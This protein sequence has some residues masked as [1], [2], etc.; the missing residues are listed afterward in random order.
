MH[1]IFITIGKTVLRRLCDEYISDSPLA[2][3]DTAEISTNVSRHW[4]HSEYC[5]MGIFNEEDRLSIGR[6]IVEI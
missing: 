5:R 1:Q 3:S 2:A 4:C 6:A